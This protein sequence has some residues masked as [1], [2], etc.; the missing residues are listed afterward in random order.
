MMRGSWIFALAACAVCAACASTGLQLPLVGR[1]RPY[2][3]VEGLEQTGLGARACGALLSGRGEK[4]IQIRLLPGTD[5]REHPI[6]GELAALAGP[7]PDGVFVYAVRDDRPGV[8]LRRANIDGSDD[9]LARFE[10]ELHALALAPDGTSAAML[11]PFPDGDERSRGG[12]LRELVLV[13]VSRATLDSPGFAVLAVTPAWIDASRIACAIPTADGPSEIVL[14]DARTR[15]V[16]SIGPGDRVVMDPVGPAFLTFTRIDGGRTAARVELDLSSRADRTVRGVLE[17]LAMLDDGLLIAFSSPT[18]G[19]EP[20][21]EFELF[22]PQV[23]LA[24]I[25]LHDL[26]NGEFRTLDPRASPTRLWSAGR[27]AQP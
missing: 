9:F 18:L 19:A 1:G 2:A 3:P 6:R 8:A 22:G 13:D 23:A 20:Q 15:S 12:V 17:P 21:F 14:F 11:A 7:T 24:T 27:L 5:L 16:S 10:R 26:R 4:P 25:K